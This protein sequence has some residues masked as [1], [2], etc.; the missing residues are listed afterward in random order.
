MCIRQP[1][2]IGG[3]GSTYIYGYVDAT[4][5]PN[6]TEKECIDFVTNGKQKFFFKAPDYICL[7]VPGSNSGLLVEE[8]HPI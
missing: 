7:D 3:S 4:Y 6:M 5:K 2:T 1:F 8:N